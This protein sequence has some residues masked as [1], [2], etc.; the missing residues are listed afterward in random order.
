MAAGMAATCGGGQQVHHALVRGG[1]HVVGPQLQV[2]VHPPLRQRH[3]DHQRGLGVLLQLIP[4][5]DLR[6]GRGVVLG[7]GGG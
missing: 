1:Q 6:G 4:H 7:L 2:L 3:R 5:I